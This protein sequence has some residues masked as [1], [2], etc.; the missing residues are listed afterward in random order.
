M[1]KVLCIIAISFY[2]TANAQTNVCSRMVLNDSFSVPANWTSVGSGAVNVSGGKCNFSNVYDYT[3]NKVY[4]GIGTTLSNTYW[5]ATCNFSI[6]NAN[7]SGSGVGEVLM[8]LTAGNLDF[9]TY[10]ASNSYTETNQDGIA[11]IL[12]STSPYDNNINDWYFLIEGKKGNVRTFNTSSVIYADSTISDYYIKLERTAKG[13]TQ[14]SV[15]SDSLFTM[16]LPGSP[17]T[18]AV[19]STIT[20]LNTVQHGTSTPGWNTRFINATIDNDLICDDGNVAPTCSSSFTYTVGASGLVNFTNNSVGVYNTWN[21]GDN[22]T[23]NSLNPSHTYLS[24]GIYTVQE[25]VTDSLNNILCSSSQTVSITN[26][27]CSAASP[28][29]SYV[30]VADSIPH[31]WDI[32]PSYSSVVS[33][34]WYWGDG[35]NSI[36]LYPSHTYDSAGVYNIC[37]TVFNVCGDSASYCQNDSIYRLNNHNNTNSLMTHINVENS[38]TTAGIKQN[39]PNNNISIYPNPNNGSFVIEPNSIT[40]QTIQIY[41]V[42][43]KMVLSQT[44][45]GKTNIDASS[46]NGGV[47]NINIIS[48][49]GVTN[50]RLVIV[51]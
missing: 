37:I 33:A 7:P 45:N 40:E 10:D 23:S 5:K 9:L 13:M 32:Y 41:D 16:Q 49:D 38:N 50:K 31:W 39:N 3:Y 12:N 43:G 27:A 48:K 46:L 17:V 29:V 35:T 18:F 36:G 44:I 6:L 8:A 22:S 19:D 26:A 47:Y 51:R 28:T 4:R 20:G 42:N 24:N 11:V 21:F 34:T 2:L 30:I 15:Y 14:L 25:N 1:K